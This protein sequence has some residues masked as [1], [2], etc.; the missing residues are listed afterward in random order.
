[1]LS[2]SFFDVY[3]QQAK[4][5]TYVDYGPVSSRSQI[6]YNFKVFLLTKLLKSKEVQMIL[7]GQAFFLS[8]ASRDWNP[9]L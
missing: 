5:Q 9:A 2:L 7:Y 8:P 4:A 1:V 3:G 6:K